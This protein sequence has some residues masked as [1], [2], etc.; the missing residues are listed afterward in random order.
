[1]PPARRIALCTLVALVA[2]TFGRICFADF[3]WWD[4]DVTI[5]H[6]LAFNPPTMRDAFAYWP[7]P[8][9]ELYVPVVYTAWGLLAFFAWNDTPAPFGIYLNPCVYHVASLLAHMGT[10]LVVFA[11]LRR[12]AGRDWAALAGA[13]LYAVHPLQVETVAWATSL[14]EGLCG[15]FGMSALWC[16]LVAAGIPTDRWRRPLA[17]ATAVICL[18]LAELSNP[19]AVVIPVMAFVLDWVMLRRPLQKVVV[20]VAPLLLVSV[21]GAVA[22]KW[23]QPGVSAPSIPAWARPLVAG[24]TVA[25]YLFKLAFPLHLAA[26]YGRRPDLALARGWLYWTWVIPAVLACAVII[27]GRRRRW[28]AA[29]ALLFVIGAAPVLGFV[30]FELQQYSTPADRYVYLSMLGPALIVAG[31][32]AAA[33]PQWQYASFGAILAVLALRAAV[34]CGVWRDDLTLWQHTVRV[35]PDSYVAHV[36]LGAAYHRLGL[37]ARAIAE[38]SKSIRMNPNFFKGH[39]NL[40]LSLLEEKR[41]DEAIGEMQEAIRLQDRLQPWQRPRDA[42]PFY[43]LGSKLAERGRLAEAIVYFQRGVDLDPNYPG[44]RLTLEQ[45]RAKLA[46]TQPATARA[47]NTLK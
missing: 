46:A 8:Q 40:A 35:S 29:G 1:M 20:R 14:K 38:F 18:I 22:A 10:V 31:W 25:F 16:Y 4:D 37:R 39:D 43:E 41:D 45:A 33:R 11:I 5:H 17:Y 24:D 7:H 15:L 23:V 9:T 34:Q 32:F 2:V 28:L 21:A 42:A 13:A 26:D 3:T 47:G 12:L 19:L 36:N 30:P 6:N 27:A 44:G